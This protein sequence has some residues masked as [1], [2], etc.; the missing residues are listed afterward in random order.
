MKR[1]RMR[2]PF[3]TLLLLA[4]ALLAQPEN[5]ATAANPQPGMHYSH[6]TNANTQSRPP[7]H[8]Y[9]GFA[10]KDYGWGWFGARYRG[11]MVSHRGY[12]GNTYQWG[13]QAGY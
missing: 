1:F 4:A 9:Y 12:Y 5:Q 8:G 11:R 3:I 10:H 2:A 7:R 6:R 13:Y